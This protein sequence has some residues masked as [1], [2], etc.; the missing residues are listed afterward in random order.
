MKQHEL[1]LQFKSTL[2]KPWSKI[3]WEGN[4]NRV[5]AKKVVLFSVSITY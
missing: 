4:E 5:S 3:Y 2:L 1:Q